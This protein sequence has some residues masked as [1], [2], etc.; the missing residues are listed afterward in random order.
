VAG[1]AQEEHFMTDETYRK[2]TQL[3]FEKQ[4]Q[5]ASKRDAALFT[6]F[7]QNL[8]LEER[9]ALIFLYAYMPLS[10]LADYQGEF[11]LQHV[12]SS[13]EA[14]AVFSWGKT[15]PELIFRHFVLPCRV[16]NENMD[17]ARMVFYKELK[18]RI[19]Q[20]SMKEA[21]LEVN[22]W[23]HEK[24]AYQGC[25]AR[26]SGPLSTVKNALGRCGEES[27]FTVSALRSV[28]I[29][30]RQC[31][32][33]RW[34]HC[35]DNHAWVEVW[36]D[37]KW[38]FLGACEPEPDLDLGWF[39]APS[40]RCMMVNTTVFGYYLG[41]EEVLQKD[42][43]F[44]K[45]N[46]LANYAPVKTLFV[47]VI[48]TANQAVDSAKVEFQLYN[49][50]EFYPIAIKTTDKKGLTS[51][52]T[53]YGDLL[54]WANK[55]NIYGYEKVTVENKDTLT[56]VLDKKTG[57][58]YTLN[59]DLTPPIPR[60][61]EVKV[62]EQ[63]RELNNS[64]VK[65]EDSIRKSYEN[66]FIDSV[67]A[68]NIAKSNGLDVEKTKKILQKSRGN[69]REIQSFINQTRYEY[70]HL[71][72][73]LL[74]AI[75]EKDLHDVTVNVLFDH[76][77]NAGIANKYDLTLNVN[78]IINPRIGDEMIK[79]YKSYIQGVFADKKDMNAGQIAE[80]IQTNIKIDNTA[81]Y[82]RIPITPKAV[83]EL[84]VSDAAS[85]D[86]LFVAIC[87][88]L[89]IPARL[90]AATKIPQ[91]YNNKIWNNQVFEKTKDA[92]TSTSYL[93]LKNDI[94][95][96]LIKPE[97]ST[98]YTIEKFINGKYVSLDYEMDSRLKTFPCQLNLEAGDY[99][100]VT[101][102][103]KQD[104]AV[105]ASLRFFS[106]K[107]AQRFELPIKLRKSKQPAKILGKIRDNIEFNDYNTHSIIRY[108]QLKS[109]NT[110]FVWLEPGK[111]PTKHAIEDISK[112]K[113]NFENW[114]G[115]IILFLPKNINKSFENQLISDM[116]KQSLLANDK[117][118]V[119]K[120][121]EIITKSKF[122]DNLPLIVVVNEKGEIIYLSNGYKIGIGE[123]LLKLF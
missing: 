51:L 116:P 90:D 28:G 17:T 65:Y 99:L 15:I 95:N 79:P 113:T 36:V 3:M 88:S 66:T 112:L 1:I 82:Y 94:A 111:E 26:T 5:L 71:C 23:C 83:L 24:V 55:G 49:Y 92:K 118:V 10:D 41:D 14:R 123:Q 67:S 106:L 58:D 117:N 73:P 75:S 31:Y 25:D 20:M 11:Y 104:G 72:L 101:G 102:N 87:R 91:Y 33:P 78:Y 46:L 32:T 9:E 84:G 19:Q 13:F 38:H 85:R 93:I 29:P 77:Y 62:S 109:K 52:K 61:I 8:S 34:A 50:A 80:W 81:N 12:K 64:R 63:A 114:G 89:G 16:N 59:M 107:P 69:G 96:G 70:K 35:D 21:A 53:G 98:H 22:H 60:E 122:A 103:R 57:K 48:N 105:M 44:T 86:L 76:L 110:V 119:L 97:Y 115:N 27:T 30:A 40:K 74:E 100:L 6:V 43:R 56:I 121:I 108:Q 37:G 18:P 2:Q 68:I 120:E 7:N 54:I 47:K 4:K 45:I 42:E 39:A